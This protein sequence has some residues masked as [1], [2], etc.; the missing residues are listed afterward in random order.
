MAGA[1]SSGSNF[2]NFEREAYSA[3][4]FD[5]KKANHPVVHRDKYSF[6]RR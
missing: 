6:D 4:G 3:L 2:G 1:F 5:K